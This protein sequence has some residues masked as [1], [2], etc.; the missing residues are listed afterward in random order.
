MQFEL[1]NGDRCK[2][3]AKTGAEITNR[4]ARSM[5]H[6]RDFIRI[7]GKG[8][9]ISIYISITWE[10]AVVLRDCGCFPG[11][12][13]PLTSPPPCAIIPTVLGGR[14]VLRSDS[15]IRGR[16]KCLFLIR[17]FFTAKPRKATAGCVVASSISFVLPFGGQKLSRFAA[18]PFPTKPADAG[19]WRGP[20]R[21]FVP[22]MRQFPLK[23]TKYSCGKLA[24]SDKKSLAESTCRFVWYCPTLHSHKFVSKR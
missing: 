11:E 1:Y 22:E 13:K 15:R 16:L 18:P 2:N 5:S 14:V 3:Q 17:C 24:F 19:L 8:Q 4:P 12:S 10:A 7:F 21:S 9:P 6:R 23:Y 20:L